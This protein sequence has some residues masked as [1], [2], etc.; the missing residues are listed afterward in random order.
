MDA[1]C[2]SSYAGYEVTVAI[3]VALNYGP[4]VF[5]AVMTAKKVKQWNG[6]EP[7]CNNEAASNVQFEEKTF[8]YEGILIFIFENITSNCR[9]IWRQNQSIMFFLFCIRLVEL[10]ELDEFN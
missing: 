10:V 3:E 7:W 8:K 5:S 6:K 1:F 4:L 9:Q 2:N